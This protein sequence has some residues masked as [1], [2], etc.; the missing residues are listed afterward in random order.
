M[1][2]YVAAVFLMSR[3]FVP[4]GNSPAN[5]GPLFFYAA[6]SSAK[7]TTYTDNAGNTQHTNPIVLDSGGNIPNFAEIWFTS[8]LTYKAVLAPANDTDPPSSPYW[9]RDYLPSIND[10]SSV[11]WVSGPTP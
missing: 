7:H 8:G 5:G 3:Q 9:T 4:G 6:G 11:E 10:V 2:V 1:A